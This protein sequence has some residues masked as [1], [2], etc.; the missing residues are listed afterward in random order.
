MTAHSI[1]GRMS[2]RVLP[3]VMSLHVGKRPVLLAACSHGGPFASKIA[4]WLRSTHGSASSLRILSSTE[5][6][7]LE[8][9]SLVSREVGRESDAMS[10]SQSGLNKLD[11]GR[12]ETEMAERRLGS[13]RFTERFPGGESFS[14]LVRRLEPCLLNIEATMEPVLV[15]AHATPCRALRAYFL[16]IP[17]DACMEAATSPAAS[18]LANE[19]S[20]VVE[21]RPKGIGGGWTETIHELP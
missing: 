11:V 1:F 8:A 2:Q 18:A 7:P 19:A 10:H 12:E 15:L 20:C 5:P 9:A 16:G 13:M 21:L 17:V 4:A 6:S 14:D 3:Y